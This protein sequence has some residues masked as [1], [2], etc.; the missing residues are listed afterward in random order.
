MPYRYVQSV[1]WRLMCGGTKSGVKKGLFSTEK[2]TNDNYRHVTSTSDLKRSE[3][4]IAASRWKYFRGSSAGNAYHE[5]FHLCTNYHAF[6][7]H[8]TV[9]SWS[10]CSVMFIYCVIVSSSNTMSPMAR[11]RKYWY[12]LI[13]WHWISWLGEAEGKDIICFRAIPRPRSAGGHFNKILNIVESV[14]IPSMCILH[15]M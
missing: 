5:P 6:F 1:I 7:R 8:V 4:L 12:F 9:I 10:H 13:Q 2:R 3:I 15:F 14:K 11:I